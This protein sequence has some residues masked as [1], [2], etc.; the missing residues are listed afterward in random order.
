MRLRFLLT[1]L[2]VLL[3]A[4]GVVWWRWGKFVTIEARRQKAME[5]MVKGQIPPEQMPQPI[6]NPEA[7]VVMEVVAPPF[8][9]HNFQLV[10]MAQEIAEKFKDKVYIK[11]TASPPPGAATC[12]GVVINGK[13]K[14]QIGERSIEFHGPLIPSSVKAEYGYTREDIESALQ[15]EI[16]EAY[17]KQ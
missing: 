5:L 7:K 1:I 13:Q 8:A 2:V 4:A 9:C 17:G 15:L 14:F 12:M 16:E 11:F 3:I 6:G 10:Q